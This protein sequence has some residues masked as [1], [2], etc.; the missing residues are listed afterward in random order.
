MD[1]DFK[2]RVNFYFLKREVSSKVDEN[3]NHFQY[4]LLGNVK[5]IETLDVKFQSFN[6][7]FLQKADENLIDLR[8]FKCFFAGKVDEKLEVRPLLHCFH[9]GF[10]IKTVTK[11]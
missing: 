5:K 3:L 7:N 2:L 11:F 8:S 6:R 1:E 10:L 4:F 9:D